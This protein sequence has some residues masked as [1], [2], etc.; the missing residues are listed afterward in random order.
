MDHAHP[1]PDFR[2]LFES[3]PGL[4]LVLSPDLTIV[5]VSDAYLAATMTERAAIVGRG[6]F[7]VFPDNPDDPATE[8][9]RNLK[10][11]LERVR[12]DRV[13]DA[14]PV[15]RYDIRRPE[16]EGG[17]FEQRFWSPVN[18]PVPASDGSLAYIIHRVEDV[19]EFMRVKQQGAALEGKAAAMEAEIYQRSQQVAEASRRLKELDALKSQFF[20]NVSHEL[21]TPL[22]LI[23]GPTERLLGSGTLPEPAAR[24]LS[25]VVRNARLLLKHVNDLLDAS[26]LEAG[27]TSLAYADLDLAQLVR[28]VAAHFDSLSSER[29][30]A[31]TL[32]TPD[33]LAAQADPDKLQRVLLNLFS[34]AFKFTPP[35]G[36][37]RCT[38]RADATG[39]PRHDRGG[40]LGAGRARQ[41]T[42]R[43]CSSGSASS[44]AGRRAASAAPG[45]G[46][47][48]RSTSCSCTTAP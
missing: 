12:R 23:L 46:S 7:D 14:M 10:A 34:N 27:K 25:G 1:G 15:Q 47:P 48:S 5:A 42:A 29:R 41:S 32:Q 17:G 24:D 18:T 43:R 19:T 31:V 40:R 39:I 6:I 20:A 44:R 28:R 30:I 37:V 11:S 33:H 3:S 16:S 9:V 4:Y 38:L 2:T 45:W 26:K 35:G 21:R 8:G 22:A 36:R 13:A